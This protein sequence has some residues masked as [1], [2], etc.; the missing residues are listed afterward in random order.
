ME[1]NIKEEYDGRNMLC[2]NKRIPDK[3]QTFLDDAYKA[4]YREWRDIDV[5]K[6]HDDRNTSTLDD[7]NQYI[8]DKVPDEDRSIPDNVYQ[9]VYQELMAIMKDDYDN[10]EQKGILSREMWL[11]VFKIYG[12]KPYYNKLYKKVYNKVHAVLD[13]E[14]NQ[15][16]R[17]MGFCPGSRKGDDPVIGTRHVPANSGNVLCSKSEQKEDNDFIHMI[18]Y[19]IKGTCKDKKLLKRLED[20]N[21]KLRHYFSN[22][23]KNKTKTH[24]GVSLGYTCVSGGTYARNGWSGSFHAN[25]N[26][27]HDFPLQKEVIRVCCLIIKSAFRRQNWYKLLMALYNQPENIHRKKYLLHNTPCTGI[28]WSC[29]GREHNMHTDRNAYGACFVFCPKTYKGGALILEHENRPGVQCKH[30]IER[31]QIV[32]GR[33]SRSPH[34]IDD[35]YKGES[36]NSIVMYGEFR[37]LQKDSYRHVENANTST[38]Q[39]I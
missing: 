6:E 37:I 20:V 19:S 38:I 33:W 28:W 35:C 7:N 17:G 5:K 25:Q 16:I 32:G 23:L 26:L 22:H 10:N 18:P 11:R 24:N 13:A 29:D 30:L 15:H 14:A 36:R 1:I 3:D 2:D 21:N 27:L 8:P 12:R 39:T 34:C 31:G 9:A 4:A